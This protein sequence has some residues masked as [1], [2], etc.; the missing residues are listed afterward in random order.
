LRDPGSQNVGVWL[1]KTNTNVEFHPWR[2]SQTV[3]S[4][5]Y[6]EHTHTP[7]VRIMLGKGKKSVLVGF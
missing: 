2:I 1:E 6:F 7:N 3:L 5:F 4:F